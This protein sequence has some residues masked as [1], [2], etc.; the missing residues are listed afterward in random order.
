M[1]R[2]LLLEAAG[3]L[4]NVHLGISIAIAP[5]DTCDVHE[6]VRFADQALYRSKGKG[7]S[8]TRTTWS[9]YHQI[10]NDDHS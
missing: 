5:Q 1:R 8:P 2:F 9:Y 3:Y 10:K 4:L 7:A 6:L